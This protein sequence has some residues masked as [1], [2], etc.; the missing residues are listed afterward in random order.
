MSSLAD[1]ERRL[2]ESSDRKEVILLYRLEST[3][4]ENDS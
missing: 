3:K 1:Y 2:L 4:K